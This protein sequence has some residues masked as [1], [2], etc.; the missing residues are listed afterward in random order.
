ML[1]VCGLASKPL[2]IE[3]ISHSSHDICTENRRRLIR[4]IF[5]CQ[6]FSIMASCEQ[7]PNVGLL[8]KNKAWKAHSIICLEKTGPFNNMNQR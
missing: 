7:S 8:L 5:P 2:K 3:N 4:Y 1:D 6:L